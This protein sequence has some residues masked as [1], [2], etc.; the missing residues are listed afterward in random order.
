MHLVADIL[1]L[2]AGR[3]R[4]QTGKI[5]TRSDRRAVFRL[6]EMASGVRS[7]DLGLIES[8]NQADPLMLEELYMVPRGLRL[9]RASN[10]RALRVHPSSFSTNQN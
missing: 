10:A 1:Q 8:G 5:E 6:I 2:D 9:L 7:I 3:A 4:R